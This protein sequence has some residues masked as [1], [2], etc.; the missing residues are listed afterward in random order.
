MLQLP[1]IRL[2]VTLNTFQFPAEQQLPLTAVTSNNFKFRFFF[3]GSFAPNNST[4]GTPT[5]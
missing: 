1:T 4:Y 3:F 2:T 5:V